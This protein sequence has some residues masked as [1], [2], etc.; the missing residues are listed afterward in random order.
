MHIEMGDDGK[1]S[2]TGLGM[3][4]FQRKHGA[5]LTLKNIIYVPGLKKNLVFFAM[6]EDRRYDVIFS[7]G[8]VFLR[9]IATSQVKKIGIRVKN[10]YKLE[11]EECVTLS[12]KAERV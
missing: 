7:K 6:L 8:K 5:P 4:T 2:V 10:I 9:H 12:T 3:I 1:Y 11:V